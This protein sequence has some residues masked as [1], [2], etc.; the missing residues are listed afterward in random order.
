MSPPAITEVPQAEVRLRRVED[1]PGP[2]GLPFVGNLL[3]IEAERLHLQLEGWQRQ[4][5]DFFRFRIAQREFLVVA[6][7][8]AVSAILRDRP[9]GF[10]RTDRGCEVAAEMGFDGLFTARGDRWRRQRPLV[11]ASFDPAHIRTYFPTLAKV[12]GR[13][14][15]RWQQ[16]SASGESIDLLPD[17]MRFTVDVTAG[18]AFGQDIDTLGSDTEVIQ[19]HLDKIFPALLRRLLAPVPYWRYL[20]LPADRQLARHLEAIH[21]AVQDFILQARRRLD[22]DPHLRERPANLIEALIVARDADGSSLDDKDLAGNV[23]TMLLAGEDTTAN[24]LAWMIYLLHRNPSAQ[25]AVSETVRAAFGSEPLPSRYDQLASLD[26]IE[27]CAHE[28]LR[29]KPVVP[30][31]PHQAVR[32]TVVAGITVPKG[33]LVICLLRPAAVDEERFADATAF[34]PERWLSDRTAAQAGSSSKRVAMPFGA[35]PRICPGRYLALQE[36]KMVMAMLVASFDIQGV[37]TPEGGEPRERMAFTMS[38]VGL[39]LTLKRR[40]RLP[41]ESGAG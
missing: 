33:T 4:Y 32:D 8:E 23:L 5:G 17:L 15:R 31:L 27:A 9:E 3:Q 39:R 35:G 1:L 19:T 10:Q 13:L 37:S 36:I 41:D 40:D 16:A 29:L 25:Q 28:T 24:T 12:T 21:Q 20:N 2:P 11:M 26:Y 30:T 14:A 18:L 34:N 22:R 38:P 7:P 6:Q